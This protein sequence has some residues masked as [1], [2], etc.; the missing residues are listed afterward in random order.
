MRRSRDRITPE[1]QI[2]FR[3]APA[4]LGVDLEVYPLFLLELIVPDLLRS[5][6]FRYI[7]RFTRGNFD[8]G[9]DAGSFPVRLGDGVHC[10]GERH[11]DRA[12][13]GQPRRTYR[14][15]FFR[16]PV[17]C[18]PDCAAWEFESPGIPST[19]STSSSDAAGR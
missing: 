18:S 9:L 12:L 6:L 5:H 2:W 10:A 3:S 17:V 13:R 1:Q 14:R 8:V 7:E 16:S 4:P 19:P 11:A 15:G